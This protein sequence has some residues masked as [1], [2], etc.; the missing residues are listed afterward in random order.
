MNV[1]LIIKNAGLYQPGESIKKISLVIDKGHI[2]KVLPEKTLNELDNYNGIDTIDA[3]GCLISAGLIDC[4]THLIYGGNRS[5]EFEQRLMGETYQSIAKKGGGI[6]STV[7]ATRA[8]SFDQLY[9]SAKLRMQSM[10]QQGCLGFEIKSG[11]G[12]DMET[13]CRM[14]L[15]A[16]CL[17]EELG[18][19]VH[20]TYLG[21]HTLPIEYEGRADEYVSFICHE[22][23]PKIKERNLAQSVDVF[24]ETIGF[25]LSQTH[26]VFDA[27]LALGF[28]IKCHAEQLSLMGGSHLA[29]S[30]GALSCDHLEFLDEKSIIKMKQA[31]TVAVLLPG[32]FYFLKE[33]QKPPINLLRKHEVPMAIATDLNPGSSPTN[34]LPLMMNMACLIFDLTVDEAWQG[35]TSNA[36]RALGQNMPELK[37]GS[38]ADFVLW[39]FKNPVDL[40]YSFGQSVLPRVFLKGL[41]YI[42]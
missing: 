28:D 4:H 8:A 27:A 18:V 41:R 40:V 5:L 15:V 13:E 10:I 21:A 17:A 19:L 36:A 32:A 7:K 16:K 23:L 30:N 11:Y 12:L 38:P 2:L 35:V 3:K 42:P 34:S 1:D 37:T 20:A 26:K 39:P 29:A 25:N 33:T 6:K 14:L 31:G 22:V 24:C 9:E